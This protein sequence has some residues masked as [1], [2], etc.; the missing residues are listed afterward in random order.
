[1][2]KNFNIK[3]IIFIFVLTYLNPIFIFGQNIYF[4]PLT[5]NDWETSS[6]N[7]FG[8]D[9]TK[10]EPLF[11][12]LQQKNTKA[13]LLLKDGKIVIEKYFDNFTQDSIW[14]WASAGKS[15][16]AFLVGLARQEGY[17]SIDDKTSKYLGNNWTSLTAEKESLITVRHQLTMTTGL[18]DNVSDSFCTLPECLVY[19]ADAGTRWAYHTALY[20]L[21]DGVIE[22][23]T[24]QSVNQYFT[25]KIR[26]KTGIVGLYLKSGYNNVFFSSARSM[27]RFG[28]LIL[29]KGIW[30]GNPILTDTNYF[31]NMINTS[32]QFN[33]SYGYLWWLNGKDSYMIPQSQIVFPGFLCKDAPADMFAA[34]GKNGQLL[35]IVPSKNIIFV[36]LGNAPDNLLVP[37]LLN[38][39]IWE[40]INPIIDPSTDVS[41]QDNFNPSFSIK[42]NYPNPFNP[43]TTIEFDVPVESKVN[44]SIYNV[45]GQQILL[46][47]NN[48]YS[49]GKHNLQFDGRDLPSGIYIYRIN[50]SSLNGKQNYSA[51]KKMTL[52]K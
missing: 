6:F 35:N 25:S 49:V 8:W 30:N 28:L 27:A 34:L 12:L 22:N 24:G 9:S 10:A 26:V 36:R 33:K 41:V 2:L 40:Y 21:L 50:V 37:F 18:D 52:L 11:D 38:N 47:T 19:K 32:Q 48:N 5:G 20:T 16:T 1:M 14:Y 45:L 44:I 39:Q 7:S 3:F 43:I 46:L 31:N 13:F 51:S 15:L 23:S 17:L 42:Q 4:P 29:N